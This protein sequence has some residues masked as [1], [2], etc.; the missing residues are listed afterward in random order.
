MRGSSEPYGGAR[1]SGVNDA[2]TKC[3]RS[4]KH[5]TSGGLFLSAFES[6]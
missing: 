3:V 4:W 2:P 1:L 6:V 5:R